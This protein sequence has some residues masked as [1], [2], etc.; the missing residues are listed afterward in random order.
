[1]KKRNFLFGTAVAAVVAASPIAGFVGGHLEQYNLFPGKPSKGTKLNILS[2][3]TP[4]F[5]GL[6]LRD[7][8]FTELADIE[9]EWTFTPFGSLQEKINSEGVAANRTFDVVNYLNSWE[10]PN[11]HWLK[12]IDELIECDGIS[13]D[14]YPAA[15]ARSTQYEGK[16]LGFPLRAHPQLLFYRSDLISEPPTTWEEVVEVGKAERDQP[17]YRAACTVLQRRR[18]LAESV[19]LDQLPVGCWRGHL[20]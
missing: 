2:I 14:R 11:A 1:M 19:H 18:Q 13:M 12:P 15:F 7:D 17:G 8:E 3:V 16:T 20:Q 9:T 10:P 6:M 4:Q 5:D